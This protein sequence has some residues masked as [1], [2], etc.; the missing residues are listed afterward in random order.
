MSV[1]EAS[2]S[3]EKLVVTLRGSSKV[4]ILN[5]IAKGFWSPTWFNSNRELFAATTFHCL[6]GAH[7][8][9]WGLLHAR[10]H[11][12]ASVRND[13][14]LLNEAQRASRSKSFPTMIFPEK[15]L[16]TALIHTSSVRL[17]SSAGTK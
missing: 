3:R 5:K 8:V 16:R 6:R 9:V 10:P 14:A 12:R 11:S 13:E 7:I 17:L 1:G 4:T 2:E 15:V